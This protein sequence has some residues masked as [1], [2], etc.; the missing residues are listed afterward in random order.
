VGEASLARMRDSILRRL[1]FVAE[2]TGRLRDKSQVCKPYGYS[3]NDSPFVYPVIVD[4]ARVACS[5]REFAEAVR[6]EGIGL[7]PHYQYVVADWPWVKRHLADDFATPNAREIRDRSFCLYLNEKY[8]EA[9]AADCAAA[10][11]K[12]EKYYAR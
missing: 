7:N 6:A 1:V 5:K 12:V 3:P 2:F 11:L 9:E 8:G 10:I 4:A